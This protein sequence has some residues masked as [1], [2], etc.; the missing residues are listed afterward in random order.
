[1]PYNG[2]GIYGTWKN[3]DQF[4]EVSDR[5]SIVLKAGRNSL[6]YFR[7]GWCLEQPSTVTLVLLP[8]VSAIKNR[9]LGKLGYMSIQATSLPG[10]VVVLHNGVRCSPTPK[11]CKTT[12][13]G[14]GYNYYKTLLHRQHHCRR[15]NQM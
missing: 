8:G 12:P 5:L 1:M 15:E 14:E 13:Q 9:T 6:L 10:G 4:K 7:C 3:K 11:M 2:W